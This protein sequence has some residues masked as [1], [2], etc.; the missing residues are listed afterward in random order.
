MSKFLTFCYF[1]LSLLFFAYSYGFLDFNLTLTSQPL[2][3]EMLRATAGV[4]LFNRPLSLKLYLGFLFLFFGLYLYLLL[5]PAPRR[6]PTR[7]LLLPLLIF[8][9]SYPL[10][11]SD[12]FKYLFAARTV[13]E[14]GANPHLVAPMTFEGDLWLRF[15]RWIHTPIPYGPTQT[16]L[17][18]P[19]YLLGFGKF[20]P[21]LFLYK[22]DQL[23]WYGLSIWAIGKLGGS[24]KAQLFFALN[25]LVLIEWLVNA[26][27]DAPMLALSLLSLVLLRQLQRGWGIVLLFVSIALKYVTVIFLPLFFLPTK[28]LKSK[29]W[30]LPL[31]VYYPLIVLSVAPIIYHYSVQ[32]QPWYV[33]WII[34]FA[35]LAPSGI[36]WWLVSF[37]SL[38]ALLRYLPFISTGLWGA[39]SLEFAL[40]TFL[41]PLIIFLGYNGYHAILSQA[42]KT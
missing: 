25:P 18:L 36:I 21:T 41:P 6:F 14:Y 13:V 35:A 31:F 39:T 3:L 22:L 5:R 30:Q 29:T 11:S 32:Y 7:S 1:T 12:V 10:L 23:F 19:Y 2:I 20:V 24:V 15:M 34:P 26:H 42:K 4:A 27:N 40:L 37:Y 16:L 8:S 28:Y 17:A 9:L 33:T 38:G